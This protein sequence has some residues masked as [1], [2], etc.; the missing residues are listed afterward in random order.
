LL[1]RGRAFA[2]AALRLSYPVV[3]VSSAAAQP[4]RTR[5]LSYS[6]AHYE[7]GRYASALTLDQSLFITRDRSSTLADGVVSLFD[8]GRWSMA[9]ELSG[10]RFS[11]PIKIPELVVPFA[12]DYYIPFFHALRGELSLTTAGAVQQGLMP[13]LHVLP[14]ARL[15]F[16]DPQRGM[17]LGGGF[18][19]TFDGEEWRTSV[20]GD[21]GGWFRRGGTVVSASIHP[22]QLQNGDLMSDFGATLDKTLGSVTVSAAAGYRTGQAER[23]DLGWFSVGATFAINRR[24]LAT[25]SIGN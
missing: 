7:D 3:V 1:T 9:G 6:A 19:R 22:Q 12:P 8:D 24:L 18:A 11:K 5:D 13:T 17:W 16:L 4:V 14:Q 20:L 25:A 10:L 21:L 15:H 23:V 2:R